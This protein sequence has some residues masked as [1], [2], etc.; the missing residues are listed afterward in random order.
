M[1]GGRRILCSSV[2]CL[3]AGLGSARPAEAAGQLDLQRL[4][5][6]FER[7]VAKVAP[8]VVDVAIL[9]EFLEKTEGRTAAVRRERRFRCS[10][11]ISNRNGEII[12]LLRDGLPEPTNGGDLVIEIA[13]HNGEV[14]G[15]NL[16]AIDSVTGVALLKMTDL[17]ARKLQPAT[18]RVGGLKE[19]SMVV[20]VGSSLGNSF[21]FGLVSRLNRRV[22]SQSFSFPRA[23]QTDIPAEAG[24]VGGVL[25]NTR[26]WMVGLLAFS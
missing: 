14:Y 13:L 18:A 10:G 1:P 22:R 19:G 12:T 2:L 16:T 21:R 15:A 25:A 8:S 26:G 23:I 4:G 20:A 6:E 3:L 7:V 24:A 9:E 11:V 17:P 5:R